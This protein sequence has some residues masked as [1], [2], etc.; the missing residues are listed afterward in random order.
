M[1]VQLPRPR[2]S[3]SR[4]RLEQLENLEDHNLQ[5]VDTSRSASCSKLH[6]MMLM[7]M[8][9]L[10]STML[11]VNKNVVQHACDAALGK[12]LAF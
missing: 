5:S 3:S 12:L 8:M 10:L 6:I 7:T 9:R 11:G 2:P 1:E 4:N